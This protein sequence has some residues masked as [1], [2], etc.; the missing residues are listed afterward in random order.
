MTLTLLLDLDDTLLDTNM[1]QFIPAYFQA[2]AKHLAPHVA[3]EVMLAVLASG[4]RT[5]LMSQDPSQTLRQVFEAEFYPLGGLDRDTLQPI[6]EQFY[7]EV[8]P[9]LGSLTKPFPEAVE[10]VE[11]AFEQG[12]QVAIATD[13]VFPLKATQH[14]LRFA[15]L[16]PEKY[17]FG[18]VS[19]YEAFHF[20]K[21]YPEY[22]AE[23]LGHLGWPEGPVLMVGNDLVRDLG[24][25]RALGLPSY[26]INGGQAQGSGPEAS[27]H[28]SLSDLRVWLASID[29][30]SLEPRF[31]SKESLLALL[32]AA[33]ASISS[34]MDELPVRCW[35]WRPAPAEWALAEVLWHLRDTEM[36][37]NLPRLERILSED[38]PFIPAPDTKAWAE[39]RRYLEQDAGTAWKEFLSNRLDLIVRLREIAEADW[40]RKARHSIFGPT[41]LQE[42]VGFMVEHD[43]L[44]IQQLWKIVQRAK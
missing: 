30:K 42:M 1:E 20:T 19:S 29:L 12:H 18:L 31:D 23:F 28:G 44:H 36:E 11:W 7:V 17:S 2:L 3:P 43:R 24:P 14:R 9:S 27:P 22:F 26:W 16:A 33:P 8:Y 41:G 21:S 34:F 4:M 25:A 40:A 35:K 13:P 15:G 39:Q 32:N 38:S 10:L 37:I 5:M 6:I